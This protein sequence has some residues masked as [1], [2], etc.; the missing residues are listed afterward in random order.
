[1]RRFV[2]DRHSDAT[3]VSGTGHVAE[4]VQFSDGTVA[5]RWR[6]P[7]TSTVVYARIDDVQAIHGHGGQTEIAWVDDA[8][9]R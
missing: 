9:R 8:D 7:V 3:G 2:L 1:M 6:G 5:L 4:G